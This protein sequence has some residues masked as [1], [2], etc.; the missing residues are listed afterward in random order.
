MRK[1]TNFNS[2]RLTLLHLKI[3][4]KVF[5]CDG[6]AH[7]IAQ[8]VGCVQ[9]WPLC[10]LILTRMCASP[11]SQNKSCVFDLVASAPCTGTERLLLQPR[12]AY[13]SRCP[14]WMGWIFCLFPLCYPYSKRNR[15]S[16]PFVL[17]SPLQGISHRAGVLKQ[18]YSQHRQRSKTT[19]RKDGDDGNDQ[20]TLYSSYVQ[21][22]EWFLK[23]CCQLVQI[24]R[25][26]SLIKLYLGPGCG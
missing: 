10:L 20:C 15:C 21:L 19:S 2:R 23:D 17:L 13:V 7:R 6:E 24:R 22:K 4:A 12:D 8:E 16:A 14:R 9:R 18:V 3:L 5:C 25:A 26:P 11:V 1:V